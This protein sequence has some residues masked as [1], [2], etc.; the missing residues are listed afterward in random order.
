[1]IVTVCVVLMTASWATSLRGDSLKHGVLSCGKIT[2]V[3]HMAACQI[4]HFLGGRGI[5][6]VEPS[7][8]Q[9]M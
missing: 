8:M 2:V 5:L 9:K 3:V 4:G 6:Y 7:E 1:M